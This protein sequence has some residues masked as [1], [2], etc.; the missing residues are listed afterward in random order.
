MQRWDK[1]NLRVREFALTMTSHKKNSAKAVKATTAKATPVPTT[2]KA[3]PVPMI[4]KTIT[5]KLEKDDLK[6]QKK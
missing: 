1:L 4:K 3:T 2:A 6:D 5:N